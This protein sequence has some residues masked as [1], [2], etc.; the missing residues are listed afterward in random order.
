[1]T[2]LIG[3][4]IG[5]IVLFGSGAAE[6][7][8]TTAVSVTTTS[9]VVTTSTVPETTTTTVDPALAPAGAYFELLARNDDVATAEAA[10]QATGDAASFAQLIGLMDLGGLV[11]QSERP[12]D[13]TVCYPTGPDGIVYCG[14]YTDFSL[15]AGKLA[16][17]SVDGRPLR[18]S[19]WEGTGYGWCHSYGGC[20]WD[21]PESDPDGLYMRSRYA[22]LTPTGALLVAWQVH[23]G[24]RDLDV[25]MDGEGHHAS[26]VTD[27]AGTDHFAGWCAS[28]IADPEPSSLGLR[29]AKRQEGFLTCSFPQFGGPGA[30]TA[31]TATLVIDWGGRHEDE[32]ELPEL[33]GE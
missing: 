2:A 31:V 17:F 18:T 13:I 24:Q 10:D 19:I 32:F 23:T 29:L 22:Y 7:D 9:L 16:H 11:V 21:D 6:P 27:S 1:V 12:G 8:L 26:Y 4:G 14:H 5:A 25:I 20:D 30:E 28:P 3:L 33:S 15:S